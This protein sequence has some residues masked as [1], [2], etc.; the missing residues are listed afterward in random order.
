MKKILVSSCT[1]PYKF[2]I[3]G[4]YCGSECSFT[5]NVG[6]THTSRLLQ[7][8]SLI[9]FTLQVHIGAIITSIYN[10]HVNRLLIDDR[11]AHTS[12]DQL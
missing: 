1:N 12:D 7:I 9:R 5:K 8:L 10:T 4:K 6:G 11:S 2:V 3:L